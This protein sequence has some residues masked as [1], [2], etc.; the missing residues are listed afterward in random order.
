M[1]IPQTRLE[2]NGLTIWGIPMGS[3][4]GSLGSAHWW[5]E[6][7]YGLFFAGRHESQTVLLCYILY[8]EQWEFYCIIRQT[9]TNGVPILD[10]LDKQTYVLFKF[11]QIDDLMWSML[12]IILYIN[13]TH[14]VWY[15]FSEP[16][17]QPGLCPSAGRCTDRK[18][19]L[20]PQGIW[21]SQ[22]RHLCCS[23]LTR[24]KSL[25]NAPRGTQNVIKNTLLTPQQ[26]Y[27]KDNYTVDLTT[28]EQDNHTKWVE[29]RKTWT[30]TTQNWSLSGN[31]Y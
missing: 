17:W 18:F 15:F 13:L 4:P 2:K 31:V 20:S 14:V 8:V 21:P 5:W 12:R 29:K 27:G 23:P 7:W 1:R 9:I 22:T 3:I 25:A 28:R 30:P 24:F 19:R 16:N 6:I 26:N 11:R 10:V